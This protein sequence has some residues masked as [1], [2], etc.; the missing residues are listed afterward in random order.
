MVSSNGIE[1]RLRGCITRLKRDLDTIE[2]ELIHYGGADAE[3]NLSSAI[4]RA[5]D[6]APYDFVFTG[7]YRH[8]G[9]DNGVD[10]TTLSFNQIEEEL[11]RREKVL[12]CRRENTRRLYSNIQFMGRLFP[13]EV[14]TRKEEADLFRRYNSGDNSARDI[15][16][17]YNQRLLWNLAKKFARGNEDLTLELMQESQ[18]KLFD[19][20][21]H[22]DIE[23]GT[24]FSTYLYPSLKKEL[25]RAA[26]RLGISLPTEKSRKIY[27]II[28]PYL[29]ECQRTGNEVDADE[30]RRISIEGG[31][32]GLNSRTINAI[33]VYHTSRRVPILPGRSKDSRQGIEE[34]TLD[35]WNGIEEIQDSSVLRDAINKALSGLLLQGEIS[36]RDREIFEL[37]HGID[38]SLE[39]R[40]LK[41]TGEL[42][43][44]K[45]TRERV[46]QVCSKVKR[47]LGQ[48]SFLQTL[49]LDGSG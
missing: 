49:W 37:R 44:P 6:I 12:S 1:G 34:G 15:L 26:G 22:F 35:G 32:N 27:A 20:I 45:L 46:R 41:Q 14:L 39:A 48:N 24:K 10:L 17:I 25:L 19:C 36:E 42:V 30:V 47:L 2:K 29:A 31:I 5:E 9:R 3:K 11:S 23:R 16:V 28:R 13:S 40:T 8:S 33:L 7:I 38:D 18:K 21:D 43:S 4:K